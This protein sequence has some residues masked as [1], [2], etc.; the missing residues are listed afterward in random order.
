LKPNSRPFFGVSNISKPETPT[1]NFRFQKKENLP[2]KRFVSWLGARLGPGRN[3]V[4]AAFACLA[5]TLFLSA[6][7]SAQIA[8]P[9]GN[10][11]VL[12]LFAD[13]VQ[14]YQSAPD[15]NNPAAFVWKF[16]APQADLFTDTSETTHFG[17]HFAG[18]TWKAD[19]DGSEVVG[20]LVAS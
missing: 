10:T 4:L 13:G 16:Q 20:M 5:G 9:P 17:T 12:S 18:P 2:M 8:P 19:V 7:A 15:P 1:N 6:G 14:I 3:A 11:P